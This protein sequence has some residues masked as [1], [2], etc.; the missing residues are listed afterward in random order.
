TLSWTRTNIDNLQTYSE[1][2]YRAG[3]IKAYDSPVTIVDSKFTNIKLNQKQVNSGVNRVGGSIL[4]FDSYTTASGFD[5]T[6]S[7]F[8]NITAVTFRNNTNEILLGGAIYVDFVQGNSNFNL[9][10]NTF[11]NIRIENG[12]GKGGVFY[13]EFYTY[14][15][16]I[17]HINI[18]GDR[19]ERNY[20]SDDGGVF[21]IDKFNVRL[22]ITNIALFSNSVDGTVLVGNEQ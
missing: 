22:N 5:I 14:T 7:V 8:E 15:S 20:A 10:G 9:A 3:V 11:K 16:D 12:H 2:N 21:H 17:N 13:F 18:I 4:N 19:Y 1:P 6:G